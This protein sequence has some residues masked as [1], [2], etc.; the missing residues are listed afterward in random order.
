MLQQS[1]PIAN[2]S[3]QEFDFPECGANP[4]N[5]SLETWPTTITWPGHSGPYDAES[6]Y[7]HFFYYKKRGV[8]FLFLG[9]ILQMIA[10]VISMF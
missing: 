5:F 6:E 2:L 10:T 8:F 4:L 7:I 1:S 3:Q 9:F